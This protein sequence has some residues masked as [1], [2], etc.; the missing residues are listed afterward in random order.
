MVPGHLVFG[1]VP[2]WTPTQPLLPTSGEVGEWE[3]KNG[4]GQTRDPCFFFEKRNAQ[5]ESYTLQESTPS[6]EKNDHCHILHVVILIYSNHIIHSRITPIFYLPQTPNHNLIT[7]NCE[8][9]G[10]SRWWFQMFFP[11]QFTV[12]VL[13][14]FLV[15]PP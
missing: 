1:H 11:K 10:Q 3:E 6:H 7:L 12:G 15:C 5:V 4:I 9:N 13:N 2:Q 8:R 14:A